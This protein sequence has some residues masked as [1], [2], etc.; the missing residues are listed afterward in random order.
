MFCD[1]IVF[2]GCARESIVVRPRADARTPQFVCLCCFCVF[3]RM[4][5]ITF[6]SK[7]IGSAT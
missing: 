5:K 7:I 1:F 6:S 4:F 3:V 2:V